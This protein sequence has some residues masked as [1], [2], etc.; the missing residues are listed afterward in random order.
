VI[1]T[2]RFQH[3]LHDGVAERGF[4][5]GAVVMNLHHVRALVGDKAR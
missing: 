3:Q 5:E 2:A 1:G 4:G